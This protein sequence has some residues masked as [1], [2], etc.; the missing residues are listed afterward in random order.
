MKDTLAYKNF[1]GSVHFSADDKVFHGKLLGVNDLVTFEGGS[2]G[3]LIKAFHSAVD[4]YLV[5]CEEVGKEPLKTH[6]GSF[7][8]RVSPEL[9]GRAIR[10]ANIRG[11]TLNKLVQTALE[12]EAE[13]KHCH[14]EPLKTPKKRKKSKSGRVG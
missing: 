10:A 13:G 1:I 12:H 8:V 11:V 5:L 6:K 4:D 3:E 14:A 9:H 2:V 7:N